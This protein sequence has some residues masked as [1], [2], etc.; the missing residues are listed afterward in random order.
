MKALEGLSNGA[1]KG[2][3]GF[4]FGKVALNGSLENPNIDGK[5]QFDN[6]K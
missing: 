5:I 6:K 2:A 4:L 3:R 1:I